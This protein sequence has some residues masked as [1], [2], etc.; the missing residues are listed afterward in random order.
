MEL[1]FLETLK[2]LPKF[3]DDPSEEDFFKKTKI[4][5]ILFNDTYIQKR[6]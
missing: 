3:C 1:D 6:Q 2:K 5:D 4:D